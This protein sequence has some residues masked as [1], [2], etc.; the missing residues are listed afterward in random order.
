MT[1]RTYSERIAAFMRSRLLLGILLLSFYDLPVLAQS[2]PPS[3]PSPP[4]PSPLQIAPSDKFVA[5][6][7]GFGFDSRLKRRKE[8]CVSFRGS[9]PLITAVERTAPLKIEVVES[10]QFLTSTKG[11]SLS[12]AFYGESGGETDVGAMAGTGTQFSQWAVNAEVQVAYYDQKF[13][14]ESQQPYLNSVGLDYLQRYGREGFRYFCG[15]RYTI[16]TY[17]GVL[18][19]AFLVF[20][21]ST[22]AESQTTKAAVS[23]LSFSA[24]TGQN[25][26]K[27]EQNL[28]FRYEVISQGLVDVVPEATVQSLLTYARN[29]RKNAHDRN[30]NP[31]VQAEYRDYDTLIAQTEASSKPVANQ[32]KYWGTMADGFNYLLSL[33]Q[34]K[35]DL[36]F[37]MNNPLDF[38]PVSQMYSNARASE[39]ESEAQKVLDESASCA[40]GIRSE[41]TSG[42]PT[43]ACDL[44]VQTLQTR[45][46][47]KHF[48]PTPR[49]GQPLPDAAFHSACANY[50]PL[51][52]T[53]T[54][55]RWVLRFDG[56]Y[57]NWNKSGRDFGPISK[58]MAVQ[59][60]DKS[61]KK[62]QT[63]IPDTIMSIPAGSLIATHMSTDCFAPWFYDDN[64]AGTARWDLVE[65]Q[66]DQDPF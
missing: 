12:A 22:L 57:L 6:G 10:R 34:Y 63:V 28:H 55:Q 37:V 1:H 44:L 8:L 49:P 52:T 31:I 60:T 39:I 24:G 61:G 56:S 7:L 27:L 17:D 38:K 29:I 30:Q 40:R 53:P 42:T 14:G 2:N 18:F 45:I 51:N 4:V 23:N 33:I 47:L 19:Q 43:S 41:S 25:D 20:N 54:Q 15:D 36:Q 21:T 11:S 48:S 65:P 5:Y 59:L 26:S 32:S 46:P 3:S 9:A 58:V 16:N 35:A 66:F 13:D 64:F 62:L 50:V